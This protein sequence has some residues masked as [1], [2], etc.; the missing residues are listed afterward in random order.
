MLHI[1]LGS[2]HPIQARRASECITSNGQIHSLTLR[3]GIG[4]VVQTL[5]VGL[6]AANFSVAACQAESSDGY[7]I[8]SAVLQLVSE[9]ELPATASGP[10]S[11]IMV[12][13]GSMVAM[14]QVLATIH[15]D[16]SQLI[17]EEKLIELDIAKQ[18][19]KSDVDIKYALKSKQVALAD[20]RRAQ[21]SNR[22]YAG[23]VSDREM[24]RLKLLVEKS[25]AE[26]DKI[27][28]EKTIMKKQVALKDAATRKARFEVDRHKV[29]A[30]IAGQIIEVNK[31]VG[32][33]VNVS[34]PVL[35][36]VQLDRLL[37]EEFVPTSV[38]RQT[39]SGAK[40]TFKPNSGS[41]SK[42]WQIQGTVVFVSP[43]IDP[44][45]ARVKVRIEFDNE[46]LKLR[47]G[48][49]GLVTIH[50]KTPIPSKRLSE[51]P[52][53]MSSEVQQ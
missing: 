30:T 35:K 45:N 34:D 39:Y 20:F 48:M 8:K 29:R 37:V 46:H 44:L 12:K 17:L 22:G 36:L 5:V 50:P 4:I 9:I 33:W 6:L 43:N 7:Q 38:A 23:V 42:S 16:E 51:K 47:P 41:Q 28:F 10:L 49:K 1:K 21:Q 27:Q 40:A 2:T 53:T 52:K 14:D 25:D 13:E 24:D 15:D 31:R 11:E 18:E 32:E 3:A 19:L 26:L